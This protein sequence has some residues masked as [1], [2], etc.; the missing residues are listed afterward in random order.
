VPEERL[1]GLL[2][3]SDAVLLPYED[4]RSASGV[5]ILSAFA[6]RLLI[7]TSA[8]GIGELMAGG[9]EPVTIDQPVTAETVADAVRRFHALPVEAYRGMAARSRARLADLLSWDRIGRQCLDI[10]QA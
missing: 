4:F 2:A 10:L 3:Q 7:T 5:A 8:G 9:L 1:H 6:E